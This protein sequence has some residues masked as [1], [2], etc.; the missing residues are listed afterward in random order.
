MQSHAWNLP[1]KDPFP[2]NAAWTCHFIIER[3]RWG[4]MIRHIENADIF[5]SKA[6]AL[7]NPVNCRGVMGKGM[8][9]EFKNR[10]PEY[11]PS[12]QRACEA[13]KLVPGRPYCVRLLIQPDDIERWPA[14]IMF[15]TKD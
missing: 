7:V 1:H 12:Y 9:L 3:W 15:P 5:K 4:Q 13:R 14:V 10:F 6:D 8:A 11:F 2:V